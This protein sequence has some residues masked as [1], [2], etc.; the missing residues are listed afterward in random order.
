[1]T[2]LHYSEAELQRAVEPF[3]AVHSV[4][5]DADLPHKLSISVR[6]HRPVAALVSGDSRRV[7]VAS[8]GTLLPHE[9][10]TR[11]PAVKVDA[12]PGDGRLGKGAEAGLVRVIAKAPEE[13]RP[14]LI[15]AYRRPRRRAGGRQ[16]RSHAALRRPDQAGGEMG[17]GGAG[18]GRH[19]GGRSPVARPAHPRAPVRRLR[20]GRGRGGGG[21]SRGRHRRA[22]GGGDTVDTPPRHSSPLPRKPARPASPAPRAALPSPRKPQHR[23]RVASLHLVSRPR[24]PERG[25]RRPNSCRT[26]QAPGISPMV[27]NPGGPGRV[28]G[29][30][31]LT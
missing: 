18:P 25:H 14:L 5:V 20:P 15:R 10:D 29:F 12:I 6:E 26:L 19:P 28:G 22:A 9:R 27:P 23:S 31:T 8:D 4:T 24:A 16:R 21:R 7:A 30:S 11:L 2:T 1:M 17:R 13:L 3:P